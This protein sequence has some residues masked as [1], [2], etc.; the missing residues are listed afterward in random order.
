MTEQQKRLVLDA[1]AFGVE[2]AIKKISTILEPLD[3]IDQ[4][5]WIV[6]K[7]KSEK[8]KYYPEIFAPKVEGSFNYDRVTPDNDYKGYFFYVLG[9]GVA[10]SDDENENLMTYD[11]GVIFSCNLSKIDP[12]KLNNGLFKGVDGVGEKRIINKQV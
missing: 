4:K 8:N 10:S 1:N 6:E 5:G 7:F 3:F 11:L 9:D 12:I 2:K